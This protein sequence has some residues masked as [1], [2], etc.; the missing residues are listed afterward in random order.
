MSSKT[1]LQVLCVAEAA[2]EL[3]SLASPERRYWV[4]P[5]NS[6]REKKKKFTAF[7]ENIR[8]HPEKFYEYFRMSL[9]S[10]D[11]LLTRLRVHLTKENTNTRNAI[12]AEER[13]T[14]TLR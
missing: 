9:K 8:K 10:F 3:N 6:D 4:H 12:S 1:L 5:M 13:L 14:V 2:G 11:E 7:Y